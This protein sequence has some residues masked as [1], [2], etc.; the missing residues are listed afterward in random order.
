MGMIKMNLKNEMEQLEQQFSCMSIE[1]KGQRISRK[2]PRERK[3]YTRLW[4]N[5]NN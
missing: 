3:H 1:D 5:K 4:E 2:T